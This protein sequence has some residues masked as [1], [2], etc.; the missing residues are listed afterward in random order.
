MSVDNEALARRF[1]AE[2]CNDR[3][4]SVAARTPAS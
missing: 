1:V 2:L 3:Q 4:A